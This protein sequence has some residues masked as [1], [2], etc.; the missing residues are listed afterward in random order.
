MTRELVEVLR[1]AKAGKEQVP[2]SIA[3]NTNDKVKI[4]AALATYLT[5]ERLSSPSG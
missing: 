5:G 4:V 1:R 2:L 3:Y